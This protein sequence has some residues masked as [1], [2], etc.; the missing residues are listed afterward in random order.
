M[1]DETSIQVNFARPMPL[2]PLDSAVLLPQQVLP[3]HIFEPRYVQLIEHALD[4]PGQFALAVFRGTRWKQEYHGKPPLMP[5]VCLAQI[6]QH[7]RLE[8]PA[9]ADDIGAEAAGAGG[10]PLVRRY[11]ILVQ[12]VCRARILEE[13]PPRSTKGPP[14]LYRMARLEPVGID[15]DEETKL[16]GIRE[17]L[18]EM[19]EDGPLSKLTHAEWVAER[20]RNQEIP[21]AVLLELVSFALPI[22]RE[23]RYRPRAEGDAG[24]RADL[25]SR[26]LGSLQMMIRLAGAQRPEEWPKGMSWN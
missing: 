21:T 9:A 23:M 22:H 20:I 19:L 18:S 3:L 24:E 11:N 17:K 6:V 5:A 4:G 7:E 26:E 10:G 14:R 12:G 15:P 2:F 13:L 8:G 25:I 16:Y 1:A